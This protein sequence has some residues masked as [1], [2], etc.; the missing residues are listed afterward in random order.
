[1]SAIVRSITS[2]A[3]RH[4]H[5]STSRMIACK[6]YA[7]DSISIFF[8][9]LAPGF[10]HV[11]PSSRFFGSRSMCLSEFKVDTKILSK[12]RKETEISMGYVW[13]M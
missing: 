8:L 4:Y 7:C 13:Y 9:F 5:L 2:A 11:A 6:L 12:L 3:A 10:A 1:M